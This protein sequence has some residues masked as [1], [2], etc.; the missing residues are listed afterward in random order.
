MGVDDMAEPTELVGVAA[1]STE[2]LGHERGEVVDMIRV[3]RT[4]QWLQDRVGQH[5]RVEEVDGVMQRVVTT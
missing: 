3:P 1:R 5:G 4:E 2:H